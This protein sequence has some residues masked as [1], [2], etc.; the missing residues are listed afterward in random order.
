MTKNNNKNNNKMSIPLPSPADLRGRQSVRATF[1]LTAKAIEAIS[2]VSIHLGI[3]QKSLFDHLIEDTEI[4]NLIASDIQSDSL[5]ELTRTQKT[6]VLSRK[7]L[8]CL[9]EAS[10]T[11]GAPR[12]ALVEFS[13]QRL[14]PV[15]EGERLKHEKR[16]KILS[17]AKNFLNQGNKLLDNSKNLLDEDDPVY[18]QLRSAI[19]ALENACSNIN[20]FVEKGSIIE[21]Y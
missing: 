1:K 21:D 4:L 8:T 10:K 19:L 18:N 16:K 3:K 17:Q 12:D 6:Y 13:I 9:E 7:T 2:I 20:I 5:S 14:L 15:I 11:F